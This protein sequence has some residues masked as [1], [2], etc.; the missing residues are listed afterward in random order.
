[1]ERSGR[2]MQGLVPCRCIGPYDCQGTGLQKCIQDVY[3]GV[4]IILIVIILIMM[5]VHAVDRHGCMDSCAA[6][7]GWIRRRAQPMY[8]RPSLLIGQLRRRRIVLQQELNDVNIPIGTVRACFRRTM[9]M[10]TTT[11]TRATG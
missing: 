5:V 3:G 4:G 1:M 2:P 6:R 10:T 11:T 8:G 7:V 9:T